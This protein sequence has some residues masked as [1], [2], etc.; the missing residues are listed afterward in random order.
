[1][2][3]AGGSTGQAVP[4]G[5]GYR[6]TPGS[7]ADVVVDQVNCGGLMSRFGVH[8]HMARNPW[9]AELSEDGQSMTLV[10]VMQSN[11]AGEIAFHMVFSKAE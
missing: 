7:A 1:V 3:S 9:T 10:Q 5:D 4:E 8:L 2:F 11:D 6:F